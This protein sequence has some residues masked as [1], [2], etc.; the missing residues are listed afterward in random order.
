MPRIPFKKGGIAMYNI[1][2]PNGSE[3]TLPKE[4]L[5]M[6]AHIKAHDCGKDMIFCSDEECIDF[7]GRLRIEVTNA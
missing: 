6:L 2:L 3:F 5:M 1:K 7:L 4:N